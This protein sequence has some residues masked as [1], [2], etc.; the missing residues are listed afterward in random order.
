MTPLIERS[1]LFG[2]PSRAAGL[3]SPDGRWLSWLAPFEGV[4]NVWPAPRSDLAAAKAMTRERIRP[5][6]AYIWA[7]DSSQILFANDTGGDE[8][9]KLFGVRPAAARPAR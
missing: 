8:N 6:R 1:R 2:N 4:M 3:I 9:F 5:I 7:P